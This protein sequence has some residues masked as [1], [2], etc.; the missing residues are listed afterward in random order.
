MGAGSSTRFGE[1]KLM[2]E[3]GGSPLVVHTIEAVKAHVDVCVLVCRAEAQ[4]RLESLKLGVE[5]VPGGS[6]RTL[7]EMAGLE[8]LG[9]DEPAL[10]GIHDA[11]RPLSS[12][13]LVERLYET[14]DRIGGAVPI[15]EPVTLLID[16]RTLGLL[17][18][19]VTVQT[20]QVFRGP[21]LMAAY[22]RAAKAGVDADDTAEIVQ[23]FGEVPIGAVPG[24][25]SNLKV[26]YPQDLEE[27]RRQFKGA[28]RSESR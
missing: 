20:P 15:L 18:D 17:D 27:V 22:V 6:T 23:R 2:V 3:V 14:A 7:S 25:R 1:D 19:V 10:I 13:A 11:A 12:A 16:R 4:E 9:S 8:A 21:E 5:I 24:E 26:T 28:S